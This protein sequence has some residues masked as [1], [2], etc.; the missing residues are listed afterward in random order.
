M[1]KHGK[2]GFEFCEECVDAGYEKAIKEGL[3]DEDKKSM[4]KSLL[5]RMEEDFRSSDELPDLEIDALLRGMDEVGKKE[6]VYQ[7][8]VSCYL[9]NFSG[10]QTYYSKQVFRNPPTQEQIDTFLDKV[11]GDDFY[12][13]CGNSAKVNIIG[14]EII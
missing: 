3:S 6:V 13:V 4:L 14:L 9:Q 7:I 5:N 12:D 8:S 10:T 2:D 1:C 11:S